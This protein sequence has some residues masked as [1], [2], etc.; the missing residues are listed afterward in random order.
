MEYSEVT[1]EFIKLAGTLVG[2]GRGGREGRARGDG[3][4]VFIYRD[5]PPEV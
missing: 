3:K 4:G 1:Y 2:K 5:V